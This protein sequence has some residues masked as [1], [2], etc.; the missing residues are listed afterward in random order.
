MPEQT[1]TTDPTEYSCPGC[2][3]DLR[4][5]EIPEDQR[6]LYAGATHY[7]RRQMSR[8]SARTSYW[9]CPDCG[10]AWARK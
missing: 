1:H 2:A 6:W 7:S 5:P 3:A 9:R 4:G 10:H 8:P